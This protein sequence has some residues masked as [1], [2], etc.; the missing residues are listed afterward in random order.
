LSKVVPDESSSFGSRKYR[1]D[2]IH[3]NHMNMCRFE[4]RVDD[5]YEKFLSILSLYVEEIEKG[6]KIAR[7]LE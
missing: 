3:A 7:N 4:N 5:G 2:S 6:L 1:N